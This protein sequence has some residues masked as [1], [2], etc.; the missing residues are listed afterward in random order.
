MSTTGSCACG[1]I[2]YEY[3]GEPAV[4]GGPYTSNVVV[5]RTNFKVT[6]G[7]PKTW[8]AKGNSGK[9]NKHFFCGTCGS[10]LYTELEVMP[11]MTCVKAGGLDGGAASLGG[12][13]G[14]EFYTKDRVSYLQGIDGAKQEPVFG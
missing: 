6:S 9:I 10:G 1:A 11:E 7:T 2:K 13:V 12:K 3:T 5:P 14:V 8:D 4:T